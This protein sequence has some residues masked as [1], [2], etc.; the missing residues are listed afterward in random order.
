MIKTLQKHGNSY[1]LV[2]EKA[3]MELLNIKPDSQLEVSTDGHAL[4]I[5]PVRDAK[6]AERFSQA[7][8]KTNQKYG[9]ALK[10]LA[11]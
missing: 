11:E 3:I 6:R 5:Q 8:D 4:T 1:A 9:Q 2:I 10:K 7:L